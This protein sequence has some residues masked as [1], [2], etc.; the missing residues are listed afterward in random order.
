M[1]WTGLDWTVL[2]LGLGVDGVDG[3]AFV[4]FSSSTFIFVFT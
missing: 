4:F 1:D 2:G 3:V